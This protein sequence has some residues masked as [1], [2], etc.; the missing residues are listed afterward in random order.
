MFVDEVYIW[1]VVF[2]YL[3]GGWF[4]C[5]L[6][7]GLIDGCL[8]LSDVGREFLGLIVRFGDVRGLGRSRIER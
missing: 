4:I 3:F 5:V 2:F 8:F 1:I 6:G 7:R